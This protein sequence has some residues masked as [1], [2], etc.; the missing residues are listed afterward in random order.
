VWFDV[1]DPS[2]EWEARW[3]REGLVASIASWR[4]AW[5]CPFRWLLGGCAAAG[6]VG[7]AG[8]GLGGKVC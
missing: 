3:R 1:W 4:R 6:V 2:E 5:I 7:G 8:G